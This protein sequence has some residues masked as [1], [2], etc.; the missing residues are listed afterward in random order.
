MAEAMGQVLKREAEAWLNN[1][2]QATASRV[3]FVSPLSRAWRLAFVAIIQDRRG[4][5]KGGSDENHEQKVQNATW[6]GICP[7]LLPR[8]NQP[9]RGT[10]L[11]STTS[12]HDGLV[13]RGWEYQRHRRRQERL[14][15]RQCDHWA[16]LR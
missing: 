13:A 14:A 3:R 2:V 16:G 1:G 5:E 11:H 15:A 8:R 9:R 6:L 10:N 12:G 7:S 4:T